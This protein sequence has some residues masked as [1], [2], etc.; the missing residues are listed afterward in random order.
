MRIAFFVS[1]FPKLSETFILNQVV[2][3]LD[4]GQ[5]VTVYAWG[6][7]EGVLPPEFERYELPRRTRYLTPP[8]LRI[9]RWTRTVRLLAS[10]GVGRGSEVARRA[11]TSRKGEAALSTSGALYAAATLLS[12]EPYDIVHCQFG[13]LGL[14]A[15]VLREL[16]AARGRLVVSFR[17]ADLTRE[18]RAEEYR[19]LLARGDLFLPVCEHFREELI[20][21][22]ADPARVR[23]HRS[24]ISL[25]RFAYRERVRGPGQPLRLLTISRLTEKKGVRYALEAVARLKAEGRRVSYRIVGDG[26][27]RLLLE[28]M[29][30]ELGLG[31]EVEIT[32]ALGHE[33][34]VSALGEAHVLLAPSV[35]AS[36]GDKEGIP[37]ALKEGMAVGLP[38]VGTFHSGIP[39]LVE[40]GI[41]G[42]LVPERDPEALAERLAW[43]DENPESWPRLGRAGRIRV[44]ADYDIDKL[45][46]RLSSLYR[47]LLS[48]VPATSAARV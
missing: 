23:V 11:W 32:G 8:R 6:M 9:L 14:R 22:G 45:N 37:N 1:R 17:G 20:R 40:D 26:E 25:S 34:V 47:E 39:E 43:L 15:L 28:G 41:S 30:A 24:G 13:G 19:D 42:F 36:D 4:A 18:G 38:V 44:E 10:S 16:G 7:E 31:A 3:L 2:G 12:E 46:A 29:I 48:D 27:L 33:G 21:Q 35:T 5:D